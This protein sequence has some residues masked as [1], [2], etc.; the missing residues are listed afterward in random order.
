MLPDL[1]EKIILATF[2]SLFLIFPVYKFIFT[3]SARKYS[4]EEFEFNEKK[5]KKK[6]IIYSSIITIIFS[7]IYT[8][9]VL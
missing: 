1:I 5:L 7:F 4:L 8:I 9:K 3:L 6:S 2:L